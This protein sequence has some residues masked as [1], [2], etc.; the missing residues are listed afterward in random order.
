MPVT[1]LIGIIITPFWSLLSQ[2]KPR[3]TLISIASYHDKPFTSDAE[4][5][6]LGFFL[7]MAG[8]NINM[9][10]WNGVYVKDML[11]SLGRKAPLQ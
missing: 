10:A 11:N 7:L 2:T 3:K 8:K 6:L 5:G 1:C 4:S 9:E